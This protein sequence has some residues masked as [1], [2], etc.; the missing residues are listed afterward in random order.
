MSGWWGLEMADVEA[1]QREPIAGDRD[2]ETEAFVAREILGMLYGSLPRGLAITVVNALL[3]AFVLRASTE[4]GHLVLWLAIML[5]VTAG[6]GIM[7]ARYLRG[8]GSRSHAR[9]LARFRL[10]AVSAGA[11]WG[12]A[13][14]L[15]MP[16][17]SVAH[18]V[19]LGFVMAGMAAGAMSSL[20]FDFKSYAAYV[21]AAVGPYAVALL[22]VGGEMQLVMGVLALLFIAA[23]VQ[24]GRTFHQWIVAALRLRFDKERIAGEL[25]AKAEQEAATNRRL[26]VEIE[27]VAAAEAQMR[28]AKEE[29]EAA[30][31][32]KS[33][34]LANMSHEIRTPMNGVLGMTDLLLKSSLDQRQRHLADTLCSS[35]KMLL[36]IIDD[37]LDLSRIEAGKLALSQEVF[38]P[39]A[40]VADAVDMLA[41]AARQKDLT[42][43][44]ETSGA[45]PPAIEGDP[46][47]LRQVCVNLIG[48]AIKFTS[49]GRVIVHLQGQAPVEGQAR[50][51]ITVS[52]TGVGIEKAAL[53]RILEPFEQA[54]DSTSRRYG[55]T[56]LGLAIC[57]NLVALMGGRLDIASEPGKGTAVAFDVE[58]P[59]ADGLDL[60]AT[61]D[62]LAPR[63][64]GAR[65]LLAE[66][67]PVNQEIARTY[68]EDLGCAVD[69]V[70]NGKA[71]VEA[72]LRN[73]YAAVLMDCQMPELDGLEA[74]AQIRA[75][76]IA[77]GL[78]RTPIVALT[79]SAFQEDRDRCFASGMDD[80]LSKP[81][82]AE[83]LAATLRNWVPGKR[84]ANG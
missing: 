40:C 48:N 74:S 16:Y 81:Y 9:E 45:L 35:G 52:D 42:L 56:G 21:V 29:A 68:L 69:V 11:A 83:Q 38:D 71:A 73:R 72:C 54:D 36:S 47:R 57:A 12:A 23:M 17:E 78:M 31:R 49:A 44:F 33:R 24:G 14:L 27:R 2:H 7:A 15:L 67:N 50:L 5:G 1:A 82:S 61:S 39:R 51:R 26:Q 75:L 76:E 8:Y 64:D 65:V 25:Q 3:T 59:L 66:D 43:A 58:M 18:Q 37:I 19:F 20:S 13:S 41:V 77:A 53:Q 62:G 63:F 6:R 46:V 28:K 60:P 10:G 84:A 30:N 22:L 34:F 55:G 79:A 32:A 4:V 80:H 70:D